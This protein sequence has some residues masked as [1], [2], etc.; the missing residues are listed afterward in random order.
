MGD[1][2]F[3]EVYVPKIVKRDEVLTKLLQ[4]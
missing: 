2:K 3:T 1:R 4:K